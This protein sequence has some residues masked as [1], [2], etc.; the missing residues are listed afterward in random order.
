MKNLRWIILLIYT[1]KMY[2]G[3]ELW[4]QTLKTGIRFVH[5]VLWQEFAVHVWKTFY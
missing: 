4:F 3:L 2:L 1:V 5:F